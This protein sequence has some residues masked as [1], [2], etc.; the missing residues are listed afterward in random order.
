[1]TDEKLTPLVNQFVTVVLPI[2]AKISVSYRGELSKSNHI[3]PL[4]YLRGPSS[5]LFSA[6][7]VN[8]LEELDGS[9]VIRLN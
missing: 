7:D 2:R 3:P 5:I 6:G 9:D 8:A 1:M 4:Y